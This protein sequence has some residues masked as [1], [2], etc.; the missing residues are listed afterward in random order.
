MSG[1]HECG[2]YFEL[3]RHNKIKWHHLIGRGEGRLDVV[4][5]SHAYIV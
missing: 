1:P 2:Q 4:H 5:M 3:E